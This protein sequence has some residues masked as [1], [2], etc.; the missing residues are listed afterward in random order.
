[1]YAMEDK[2]VRL[3]MMKKHARIILVLACLNVKRLMPWYMRFVFI[4][5]TF[6]ICLQIA[7]WVMMSYSVKS[8][9]VQILANDNPGQNSGAWALRYGNPLKRPF[10]TIEFVRRY[11]IDRLRLMQRWYQHLLVRYIELEFMNGQMKKVKIQLKK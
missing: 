8:Q 4:T 6:V 7:H 10:M 1:M 9:F 5:M 3:E 11:T 2:I